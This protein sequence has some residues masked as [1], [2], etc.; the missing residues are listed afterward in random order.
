MHLENWSVFL[1]WRFIALVDSRRTSLFILLIIRRYQLA[2]LKGF[3][4]SDLLEEM[5]WK[6]AASWLGLL[7][8]VQV[9]EGI[10]YTFLPSLALPP[11]SFF[12]PPLS[13]SLTC[14]IITPAMAVPNL[15][16]IFL[17]IFKNS[18][19]F[20]FGYAL[21]SETNYLR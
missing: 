2:K 9:R 20:H 17:A 7:K 5:I 12:L 10:I 8:Q 16:R 19:L 21:G 4:N 15:G 1:L 14:R 13:V 18:W 6:N 3:W 11:L